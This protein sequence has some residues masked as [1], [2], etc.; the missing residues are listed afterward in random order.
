MLG[1]TD[2]VTLRAAPVERAD[3]LRY[4]TRSRS[5]GDGAL[6]QPVDVL[7]RRR[8]E[9]SPAAVAA[10]SAG[11]VSATR[12]H[13]LTRERQRDGRGSGAAGN[14]QLQRGRGG[15]TGLDAIERHPL[16]RDA[17][18]RPVVSSAT[19]GPSARVSVRWKGSL[20]TT[21]RLPPART[22]TAA[23]VSLTAIA[24]EPAGPLP[25]PPESSSPQA[26]AAL[27]GAPHRGRADGQGHALRLGRGAARMQPRVCR[28]HA[29]REQG[30]EEFFLAVAP[31]GA[32]VI[33]ER[34]A[35]F[36]SV[37]D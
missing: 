1:C 5:I 12:D 36:R 4:Q 21:T 24:S 10:L 8:R 37:V 16:A 32:L 14:R 33:M 17:K 27:P 2:I 35:P 11:G 23:A 31:S 25:G 30:D 7:V 6:E 22:S 20:V 19:S 13:A 18:Y 28:A 34:P 15:V 9:R 29:A 26:L 3:R